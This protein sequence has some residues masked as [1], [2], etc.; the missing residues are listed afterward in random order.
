MASSGPFGISQKFNLEPGCQAIYCNARH[1][2][3]KE[4]GEEEEEERE[5]KEGIGDLSLAK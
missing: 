5:E 2:R 1:P 3:Q 4:R